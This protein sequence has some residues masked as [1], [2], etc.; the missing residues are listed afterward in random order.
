MSVKI[1][2][3]YETHKLPA[4][5]VQLNAGIMQHYWLS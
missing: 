2:F 1:D 4:Q 3:I 5:A